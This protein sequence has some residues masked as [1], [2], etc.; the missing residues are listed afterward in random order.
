MEEAIGVN[1]D[2]LGVD[3]NKY[4]LVVAGAPDHAGHL[5]GTFTPAAFDAAGLVDLTAR[6]REHLCAMG[7]PIVAIASDLGGQT[8]P[9]DLRP[10]VQLETV[11]MLAAGQAGCPVVLVTNGAAIKHLG[12][13]KP[14]G[15]SARTHMREVVEEHVGA[16]R[17]APTP[18][19]RARALA[20]ALFAARC[21]PEDAT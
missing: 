13:P 9:S 16:D 14:S 4:D 18:D 2:A 6:L 5:P 3:A 15:T 1:V 20:V 19:R 21:A 7:S 11:A 17:I 12:V 8:K 10:R